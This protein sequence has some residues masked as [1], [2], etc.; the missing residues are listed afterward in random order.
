MQSPKFK[1]SKVM[2]FLV[3][4]VFLSFSFLFWLY[5]KDEMK[6]SLCKK[7]KN[8]VHKYV[9]FS[10]KAIHLGSLNIKWKW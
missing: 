3:I 2:K 10:S 4:V 5:V 7:A 6:F 8:L 9:V 1:L